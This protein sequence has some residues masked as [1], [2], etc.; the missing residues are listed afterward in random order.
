MNDQ[1]LKEKSRAGFIPYLFLIFFAVIFM[2]DGF[3]IYL[4]NKS[5]RGLYTENAYQKG[6][7]YNE[8]LEYVKLQKKLGWQF[9][10]NYVNKGNNLGELTVCL[11]DKVGKKITAAKI[12]VQFKRPVEAGKDFKQELM[13]QNNCYFGKIQ[14]PLKGQWEFEIQAFSGDNVFQMVKRYVVR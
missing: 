7:K 12:I 14:F 11:S 13:P 1:K 5:W 8:T 4:A 2:V 9:E 10:S 3:Y 6:I